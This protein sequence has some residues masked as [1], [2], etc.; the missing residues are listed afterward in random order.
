MEILKLNYVF[1][2]L[3]LLGLYR[4]MMSGFGLLKVGAEA[5]FPKLSPW[6]NAVLYFVGRVSQ[7]LSSIMKGWMPLGTSL[8]LVARKQKIPAAQFPQ[9]RAAR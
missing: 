7:G 5:E 4:K 6:L 3:F 9:Y 2:E 1:P 8:I